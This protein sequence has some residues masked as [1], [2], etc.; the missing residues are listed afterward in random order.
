MQVKVQVKTSDLQ[1]SKKASS[2]NDNSK[3]EITS[4]ESNNHVLPTTLEN[5]YKILQPDEKVA[6]LCDLLKLRCE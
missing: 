3:S 5:Y 4:D 1:N 6:Y 2:D